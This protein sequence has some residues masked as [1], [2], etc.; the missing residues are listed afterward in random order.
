MP[1]YDMI[2][3]QIMTLS[4][5]RI[6]N[7]FTTSLIYRIFYIVLVAFIGMTLPF[8]GGMVACIHISYGIYILYMSYIS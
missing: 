3:Y 2:E 5:G 1:A 7:S 8:L 4:K 6:P